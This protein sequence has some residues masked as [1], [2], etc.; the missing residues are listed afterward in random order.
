MLV[1]GTEP[2]TD[3]EELYRR[4][5]VSM[6][7]YDPATAPYLSPKAFRPRQDDE[8]GLSVYRAKYKSA[9]E[10][11]KSGRGK[12]YFVGVLCAGDLRKQEI[13]VIPKPAL[14]DDPGH[15]ELPGLRYANRKETED[16]QL[17][18]AEGLCLRIEGPFPGQGANQ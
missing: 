5:P 3:D 4:I 13:M 2:I 14:P 15:A 7:W 11:G 18:L 1:D 12:R 9:E 16:L 8:T 6:N 10:V 17:L